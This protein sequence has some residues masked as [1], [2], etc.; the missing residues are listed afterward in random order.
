LDDPGKGVIGQLARLPRSLQVVERG[1][2]SELQALGDTAN[3][4]VA[5][6]SIFGGHRLVVQAGH[7]IQKQGSA[8]YS[9]LLPPAR[10]LQVS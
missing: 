10:A 7:R 3:H 4:G 1:I 6:D 5:I 2:E 8:H 9:A